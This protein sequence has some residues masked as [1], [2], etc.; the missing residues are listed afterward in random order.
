MLRKLINKIKLMINPSRLDINSKN[1]YIDEA[2]SIAKEI[3]NIL[4]LSPNTEIISLGEN[5][6]SAWYIKEVSLKK[7]SYPFDWTYSSPSIIKHCI[8]DHFKIFLDKSF[9]FPTRSGNSAG[10][11]FYHNSLFNHRNPLKKDTDYAYYERCI[12]RFMNILESKKSILFV[13]T[14]VTEI[15]K[16]SG[17]GWAKGFNEQFTLPINQN[18]DDMTDLIKV[19]RE[20]NPNCKFLF[21][22]QYTEGNP[23]IELVNFKNDDF[24]WIKH[25]SFQR[26]TGVFFKDKT[27]DGLAK[28]LFSSL[29]A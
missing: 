19:I 6:N 12:K 14:V 28:I 21:I 24:I 10:H 26:N 3:K 9:I 2:H 7:H 23:R 16:R 17:A 25:T 22:E 20:I 29:K 15:D 18:F 5:C 4:N 11:Q 13:M 8:E 27:D 1:I